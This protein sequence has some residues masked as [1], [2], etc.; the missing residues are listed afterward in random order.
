M[1]RAEYCGE[2]GGVYLRLRGR[3]DGIVQV[4]RDLSGEFRDP[5]VLPVHGC[6]TGTWTQTAEEAWER[7]AMPGLVIRM[8]RESGAL[9]FLDEAGNLLLR[10][11]PTVRRN[12]SPRRSGETCSQTMPG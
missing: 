7:F 8:D 10:E 4:T 11:R 12:W 5:P 2:T 9:S 3:E 6:E 1:I